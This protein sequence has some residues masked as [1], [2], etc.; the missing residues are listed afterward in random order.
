MMD[1]KNAYLLR[2]L[3]ILYKYIQYNTMKNI[4]YLQQKSSKVQKFW[5]K[6]QN[7]KKLHF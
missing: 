4:Q 1:Y 7:Y 5:Q 3:F 2:R 6:Y